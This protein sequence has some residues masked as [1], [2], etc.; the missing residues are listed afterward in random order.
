MFMTRSYSQRPRPPEFYRRLAP[1]FSV[2]T[3][4]LMSVALVCPVAAERGGGAPRYDR[5]VLSDIAADVLKRGATGPVQSVPAQALPVTEAEPEIAVI[6]AVPD[7]PSPATSIAP[8]RETIAVPI[9]PGAAVA[10]KV[11][12]ETAADGYQSNSWRQRSHAPGGLSFASGVLPS[13]S[14]LDPALKDH[15]DGLRQQGH[16]FTYGFVLLRVPLDEALEQKLAGFGVEL[17]GRHDDHHKARLPVASL[18]PIAA[19]PEVEWVGMSAREQKESPEL[20]D[21]RG[22]RTSAA[23]VDDATP[24]PVVINLFEDDAGGN[25]RR[26]LEAAGVAIGEYDPELYFYRAVASG[27][28]IDRITEMDFVLYVELIGLGSTAHDQSMSVVDADMIRPGPI[29]YG[30]TRFSGA[31]VALGIIDTGVQ[32]NHLDLLDKGLCGLN[33]TTDGTSPLTDNN[34]HGTHVMATIAGTGAADSRFRGVAPGLG[35]IMVAKAFDH[36][37]YGPASWMENAMDWMVT[38]PF[39]SQAPSVI[40]LSGGL[41]G[42]ALTGTDSTSRKVDQKVWSNRQL[43]VVAAGNEGSDPRTIRT[44]GV[45]KNALTVG[46]IHDAGLDLYVSGTSSRGPT[47]DGRMKP[48]LVA[49]GETITSAATFGNNYYTTNQGKGTSHAAGHVTGLAATLMEHYPGLQFNPALLRAHM[50]ATAIPRY[51]VTAKSNDVGLGHV[52]GYLAHWSHT[53]PDGWFTNWLSG[54]VDSQA[55]HYTDIVVPPGAQRLAVVLTW[56]EPP[57]SAGATKAVIWDLDLWLDH[58]ADCSDSMGACGEYSSRSRVDNVEY[59]VVNSPP[60]GTYRL[61]VSPYSAPYVYG[62]PFGLSAIIIRGDP[63]PALNAYLTAPPTATVGSPFSVTVT[64]TTK[65]YAASGVQVLAQKAQSDV[66]YLSIQTT[67]LDGITM[68]FPQPY[69]YQRLD[70]PFTLGN[71]FPSISRSATWTFRADTPGRKEFTITGWSKTGGQFSLVTAVDVQPLPMDLVEAA[72]TT[73]PPAPMVAPGTSFSVTDTVRNDGMV[74][75]DASTTRYY[76]SLDAVKSAADILLTGSHSAP[77]VDPGASHTATVTVSVPGATALNSYFLIACADDKTAV[78]ESN[79]GN[80]CIASP[81]AI[82]TVARPDLAATTMTASP[83]APVRA[84]GTTFSVSDTVQNV[85]AVPAAS[86]TTR[87]YLSLDAVKNAGDILLTGSRGVPSLAAGATS[88]GTVTVTI[89]ASAPLNAYFLLACADNGNTVVEANEANNCIV[90]PGAVVTVGRPDLVESAVSNPPATKVRG[91]KFQVTDTVENAG[92]AAS[93]ASTTRYYLSLDGAKNA[94]DTLLT[95][96]RSSAAL[97]PGTS[98]SGTITVTIPSGTTPNTYFLLACADNGNA[99]VE[100]NETNNCK[101]SGT[102]VTIMP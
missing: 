10:P 68:S 78:A 98:D 24:I 54:S 62:L 7:G 71:L 84:P 58:N 26:E 64:A 32:T 77:E 44:P 20:S 94:G 65:T 90:T 87:Y 29:S 99:V 6:E 38:G 8:P 27:P 30:L 67:R 43:Y 2:M 63:T 91:G 40:N 93:K 23:V 75:A 46:S 100:S 74:R 70:N 85:G 12:P 66:T 52:S 102:T 17:L 31:P 95:G 42:Y 13:A 60:A 97:A 73:N 25:F 37:D 16:Q 34:G 82:V 21:L 47:G 48:N 86:S 1:A 92:A 53:N 11:I 59:L 101:A 35:R 14:G 49:P 36:N 69:E 51:D 39:C 3:A 41:K 88:S 80:N 15:A 79:E 96:G 45:A 22:S 4:V 18:H 55:Y 83:S 5:R 19:L 72:L 61:K 9:T 50:M 33:F 28:V 81:G 56:D 57:Q 89:P 76:L